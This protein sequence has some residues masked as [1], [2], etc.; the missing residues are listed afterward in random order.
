MSFMQRYLLKPSILWMNLRFA[1]ATSRILIHGG[2][3]PARLKVENKPFI[4]AYW[5]GRMV[6]LSYLARWYKV[7]VLVARD[8]I[9]DEVVQHMERFGMDSIQILVWEALAEV[10]KNIGTQFD[11]KL[12]KIFIKHKNILAR[13]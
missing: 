7:V 6:F 12:A 5:H 2:N 9:G 1:A 8:R 3:I 4:F 11:P 13:E 10:K